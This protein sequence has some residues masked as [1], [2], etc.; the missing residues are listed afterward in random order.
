MELVYYNVYYV[1]SSEWRAEPGFNTNAVLHCG[2]L[3]ISPSLPNIPKTVRPG[4][5]LRTIHPYRGNYQHMTVQPCKTARQEMRAP[6]MLGKTRSK[7]ALHNALLSCQSPPHC[8][9]R[10]SL[11]R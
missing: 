8:R 3:P 4:L 6:P 5:V 11:L 1:N 7:P 10:I 2:Y 9:M